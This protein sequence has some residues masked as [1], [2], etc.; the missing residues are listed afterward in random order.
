MSKKE[1]LRY[2]L[3]RLYECRNL[4]ISNLWQRSVFLSVFLILCFSAYGYLTLEMISKLV[5]EPNKLKNEL[6]I[7]TICLFIVFVG[8]IFSIIWILMSKASKG[9][10]EVYESAIHKFENDHY[11]DLKL[12]HDNIMGNMELDEQNK[13]RN[14]FSTKAGSYSPS[15]INIAIGQISL[16]LW[17]I[18]CIF[19]SSFTFYNSSINSEF[20]IATILM[21]IVG[22]SSALIVIYSK[23]IKSSFL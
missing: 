5:E 18:F 8:M 21:L 14:I 9:W 11:L 23:Y 17:L 10:Y 15:R 6:L 7:N 12:P 13:S 3:N 4:E 20:S 16:C 1:N 19:H 2:T 22:F